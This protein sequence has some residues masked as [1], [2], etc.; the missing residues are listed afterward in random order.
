MTKLR[1]AFH[2]FADVPKNGSSFNK[3]EINMGISGKGTNEVTEVPAFNE[4]RFEER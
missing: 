2:S 1:L 4:A 3:T